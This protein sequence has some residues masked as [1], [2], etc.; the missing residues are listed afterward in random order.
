VREH[1][2]WRDCRREWAMMRRSGDPEMSQRESGLRRRAA[3]RAATMTDPANCWARVR[4]DCE[5]YLRIYSGS[6]ERECELS[7]R[8]R[9]R[10]EAPFEEV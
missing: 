8:E 4:D 7:E 10:E 6:A 9:Q 5:G 2:G 1:R 3:A